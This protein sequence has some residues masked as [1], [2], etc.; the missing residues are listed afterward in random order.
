MNSNFIES[1]L[2][3]LRTLKAV[4][5]PHCERHNIEIQAVYQCKKRRIGESND[6]FICV[7]CFDCGF[8]DMWADEDE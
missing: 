4:E 5:C 1:G 3:W 2:D 7:T 6:R 8:K